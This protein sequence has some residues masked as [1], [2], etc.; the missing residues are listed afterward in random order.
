MDATM[1]AIVWY[2][3]VW[4]YGEYHTLLIMSTVQALNQDDAEFSSYEV[5][6]VSSKIS[7]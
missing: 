1:V 7:V 3:M 2:G 5:N 4:A 6:A